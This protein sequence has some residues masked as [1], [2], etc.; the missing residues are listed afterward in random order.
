M[1]N[2]FIT[3]LD[4]SLATLLYVKF[5]SIFELDTYSSDVTANINRS[6][7]QAPREIALREVAEKRGQN[8]LEF[9]NFWRTSTNVD[10]ERQRTPVARR[11][12]IVR[13]N[14]ASAGSTIKAQ[15]V[16]LHY[17]VWFWSK[18]LNKINKVIEE[19]VFWQQDDPNIKLTYNDYYPIE[20]DL[21]FGDIGDESTVSEKYSRG[22]IFVF[23]M[24]IKMDAWILRGDAFDEITSIVL[25]IYDKDDIDNYQEI[26]VDNSD[27]DVALANQLRLATTTIT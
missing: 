22:I 26:V 10:L 3:T 2:A 7:I 9:I 5:G 6:V 17:N 25:T 23:K 24:P 12:I 14:N 11:G 8:F 1:A 15:P 13:Q 27:Q 18:S 21:H 16:D 20:P 4:K 19:Y